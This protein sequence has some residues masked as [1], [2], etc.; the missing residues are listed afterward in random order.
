MTNIPNFHRERKIN[1][2]DKN[3]NFKFPRAFQIC[4][5]RRRQKELKYVKLYENRNNFRNADG[6]S[7]SAVLQTKNSKQKK[8]HGS[9][10]AALSPLVRL[11]TLQCFSGALRLR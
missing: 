2:H 7:T 4:I 3:S 6:L 8:A 1:M 9:G 10:K 5:F 11:K